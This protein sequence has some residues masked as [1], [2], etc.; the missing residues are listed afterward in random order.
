MNRKNLLRTIIA[1]LLFVTAGCTKH[2][3]YPLEPVIKFYSFEKIPNNY[4][5][6]DK[7][8]LTV[9]F[10]DGD[11][12]IGLDPQ[13]TFPPFNYGSPYYYNCY[14][15]YYE[16][17]KGKFEKVDLPLTNNARIPKVDADVPQRGIRGNIE[18]E[19]Y[20]NNVLSP[21]DTIKFSIY[22]IDRALHKSN[23]VETP[24]IIIDKTP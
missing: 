19:L 17:R 8:I 13:D 20:I 24:E 12:D 7:G 15:D 10:T 23:I 16:K 22:I 18:V 9:S 21:Y 14:I 2:E 1:S 4:K 6:D 5:V 11:G 3:K